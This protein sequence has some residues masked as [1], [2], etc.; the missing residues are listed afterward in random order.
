MTPPQASLTV[1]VTYLRD[2]NWSLLRAGIPPVWRVAV[3]NRGTAPAAGLRLRLWLAHYLDSGEVALPPVPPGKVHEL[4]V[5]GI[6]WFRRDFEAASA[7]TAAADVTWQLAVGDASVYLP[8]RVLRPD[9]WCCGLSPGMNGFELDATLDV[10]RA[11]IDLP[12]APAGVAQVDEDADAWVGPPPLQAAAAA[13]VFPEAPV[14]N[15]LK[16]DV[17]TVLAAMRG[18]QR[19]S[20]D[21]VLGEAPEQ[22]VQASFTAL[23]RRYR[24]AFHDIEEVS[25][26]QRSQRV[27]VPHGAL[28][29]DPGQMHGATCVDYALLFCALLEACGLRPQFVLV[30]V[31][32]GCHALA[33]SWI[34]AKDSPLFPPPILLTDGT[35]LAKEAD[36]GRLVLVDIT[37]FALGKSYDEARQAVRD[38]LTR[39][40]C[41]LC[42]ALD[43][44]RARSAY[45]ILPLPGV[46]APSRGRLAPA[47]RHPLDRAG[48][49]QP[50]PDSEKLRR[51][52]Q[53]ERGGVLGV[54]AMGGSG[55]TVLVEHFLCE[56]PGSSLEN[57]AVPNR[58]DLP[59]PTALFVWSFYRM[60]KC[61]EFLE[62]LAG[63]LG[64]DV[65]DRS[66][67]GQRLAAIQAALERRAGARTLLVLDGVEKLQKERDVAGQ[68]TDD[69]A[70]LR[71][72]LQWVTGRPA[73][74]W[75]VVTSRVGL[76]DLGERLGQG[77]TEVAVD[78]LDPAA[79]IALLRS[80]GVQGDD[81]VLERLSQE[82]GRHAL[83]LTHVGGL[84]AKY[85]D[86]NPERASDLPPLEKFKHFDALAQRLARVLARYEELLSPQEVGVLKAVAA[87]R[88]PVTAEAIAGTFATID[89]PG[90]RGS[91]VQ[92]PDEWALQ[93]ILGQ[94]TDLRLLQEYR[95]ASGRLCYS[96]HPAIT[97]Y[98]YSALLNDARAVHEG[99]AEYLQSALRERHNFQVRTTGGRG[100]VRT[101]GGGSLRDAPFKG[102][103]PTDRHLLDLLEE[104]IYHATRSCRFEEAFALYRDN[105]GG[106][107]HLGARLGEYLRGQR[108]VSLF[109]DADSFSIQA[110]ASAEYERYHTALQTPDVP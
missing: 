27:R 99:A 50:R 25:F 76:T 32:G 71:Q 110:L 33:G 49:F 36:A 16:G 100:P 69:A 24:H 77:Y 31:N 74:V 52:W 92:L 38:Y 61:E 59:P 87:F 42:Y 94:L 63:Y 66:G 65:T 26:E 35:R 11:R 62:Q 89:L 56:L 102:P 57:P 10:R 105:L 44:S 23:F 12:P 101:R 83:T 47:V 90:F 9:E 18:E 45:K 19:P 14:V 29:A 98:F 109:L 108:I 53:Q 8:V 54:I 95:D 13:L 34:T 22:V 51:F 37:S 73:G 79:A 41:Q 80:R 85:C 40:G 72:L 3:H 97:Q 39:E 17:M 64:S 55:K 96:S 4:D 21:V 106:F 81:A 93:G 43:V 75:V 15:A 104:L 48:H 58:P 60:P 68:F 84:L 67:V 20:L 88:L 46:T 28:A 103:L 2:L 6:S 107:D 30:G 78:E 5:A 86:G 70:P 91:V 1:E 82:F 7:L